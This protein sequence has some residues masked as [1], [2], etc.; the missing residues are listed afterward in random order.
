MTLYRSLF[1]QTNPNDVNHGF[2]S[3][4]FVDLHTDTSRTR[5]ISSDPFKLA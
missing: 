3:L 2:V 5:E 1:M 4:T